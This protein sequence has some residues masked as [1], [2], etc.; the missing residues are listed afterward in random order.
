MRPNVM[1]VGGPP[2]SGTTTALSL[3][4]KALGMRCVSL[5]EIFRRM[6]TERGMSLNEFGEYVSK[7][8]EIDRELDEN[9]I[10]EAE[11]GNVILEG[12]LSGFM[13]WKRGIDAFKVW[14]DA[15]LEVRARRVAQREGLPVDVARRQGIERHEG[16]IRRYRET[17]GL[18]LLETSLYDLVLD[19]AEISAEEVTRRIVEK[20]KSVTGQNVTSDP[21]R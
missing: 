15:P 20:W 4:G 10:K 12:R 5:G 13:V 9:Q 2:G 1:T 16:E 8:P 18:E 19:T 6:A 3:L 17:Y 21:K 7:H 11:R 14:L